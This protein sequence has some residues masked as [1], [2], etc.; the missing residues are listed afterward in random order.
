MAP[1]IAGGLRLE[2]DGSLVRGDSRPGPLALL[3]AGNA[4]FLGAVA[5]GHD[6]ADVEAMLSVANPYAVV[7]GCSDSRVPPEIV[8]DESVGRLFVIRVAANLAAGAEIGTIEFALARWGCPLVV[9]LGH[10]QCSA[11]AA[12]MDRLPPGAAASP[13][14]GESTSLPSLIAAIQANLRGTT[15]GSSDD[16]WLD[17][18]RGNVRRTMENLAAASPPVRRRMEDGRLRVAGA[19]YHVETGTVEFLE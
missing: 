11:I 8:F 12:A 14:M 5:A 17:A 1:C 3:R 6:V 9:V 19:I 13:D 16:L 2:S 18:V 4:R 15:D 10:S 7:L